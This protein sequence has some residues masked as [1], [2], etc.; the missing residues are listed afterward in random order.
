ME[1]KFKK[2]QKLYGVFVR[3]EPGENKAP[4]R[5]EVG[6]DTR[7][8]EVEYFAPSYADVFCSRVVVRENLLEIENEMLFEREKDAKQKESEVQR[9]IA[10]SLYDDVKLLKIDMEKIKKLLILPR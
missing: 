7:V 2:G 8:Q 10:I 4:F 1:N 9:R 5:D 6:R 3:V